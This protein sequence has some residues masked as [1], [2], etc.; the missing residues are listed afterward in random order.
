MK[1][2]VLHANRKDEDP[3]EPSSTTKTLAQVGQ[4]SNILYSKY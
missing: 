3:L 1:G 2:H 4:N